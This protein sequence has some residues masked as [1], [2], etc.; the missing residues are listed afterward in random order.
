MSGFYSVYMVK[1]RADGTP[2]YVGKGSGDRA[3]EQH[4]RRTFC[5]VLRP[6]DRSR[7]LIFPQDS[8]ADALESEREL[9]A[10]FGR[11]TLLNRNDG[12]SRFSDT[13]SKETKI[14]IG[15]A[16]IRNTAMRR[17]C[18]M[19]ATGRKFAAVRWG[20]KYEHRLEF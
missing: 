17:R 6:S 16:N 8:E 12:G 19:A 11:E 3:F 13:H 20:V 1:C 15:L 10:L 7:I 4:A 9:I 5:S 14:K 18:E 2:Y